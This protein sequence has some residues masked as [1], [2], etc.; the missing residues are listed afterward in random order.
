MWRTG[1]ARPYFIVAI[2][3]GAVVFIVCLLGLMGVAIYQGE[4]KIPIFD[5]FV[6]FYE[7]LVC[8]QPIFKYMYEVNSCHPF[9]TNGSSVT[10][11]EFVD[12]LRNT[13]DP[14]GPVSCRFGDGGIIPASFQLGVRENGTISSRIFLGSLNCTPPAIIDTYAPLGSCF[15][16][17]NDTVTNC[18]TSAYAMVSRGTI[19]IELP[20]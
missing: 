14:A 7:T 15:S 1:G 4:V 2:C 11:T 13:K 20:R 5:L 16:V 3:A 18:T 17:D 19:P 12:C 6:T 10:C 8:E 9:Y